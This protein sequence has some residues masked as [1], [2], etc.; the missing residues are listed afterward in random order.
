METEAVLAPGFCDDR[1][2]NRTSA[3]WQDEWRRP[4][5]QSL[6]AQGDDLDG[7]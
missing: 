3:L 6:A 4:S 1:T 5:V 2:I 7:L